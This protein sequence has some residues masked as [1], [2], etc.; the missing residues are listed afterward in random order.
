MFFGKNLFAVLA[1]ALAVTR[2]HG[3]DSEGT[4]FVTSF[5]GYWLFDG[6]LVISVIIIPSEQDTICTIKYAQQ[7]DHKIVEIEA[8]ATYG[9]INEYRLPNA[10]V[11][12]MGL[13]SSAGLHADEFADDARVFVSCKDK[14][15]LLGK[16]FYATM[17]QSELFLIPSISSA[18]GNNF[19]VALPPSVYASMGH[20]LVL[21]LPGTDEVTINFKMY[22]N[23]N[24]YNSESKTVKTSLGAEQTFYVSYF[25]DPS[26]ITFVIDSTEPVMTSLVVEMASTTG[27]SSCGKICCKNYMTTML[28]ANTV[29]KCNQPT[30]SQEQRIITNDFSSRLYISPPVAS[31]C[32]EDFTVRVFDNNKLAGGEEIIISKTGYT[33]YT[34]AE[35]REISLVSSS[36]DMSVIRYGTV[37]H[38]GD[39]QTN[40]GHFAHYVPSTREFVTGKSQ[41]YA[42]ANDCALEVYTSNTDNIKLDGADV[43][44]IKTGLVGL[45]GKYTQI[46]IN[47]QGLGIH[48]FESAGHYVSYVVCRQVNGIY[49]STGYLTGFNKRK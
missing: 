19:I 48:T 33:N 38:N 43:E 22:Q 29:K 3:D 27:D 10:E 49:D 28:L 7:S 35:R 24:L 21:P 18:S 5:S 13:V 6:S 12:Y 31:D 4:E 44:S 17:A 37:F 23:G 30:L 41:F 46:L 9:K 45:G 26:N 11:Y 20:V 25:D 47:I 15:K 16:H 34:F 36:G 40:Y 32:A 39:L 2:V 8:T 42:L 1:I 14:V